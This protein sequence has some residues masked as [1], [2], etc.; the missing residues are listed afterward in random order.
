MK[1]QITHRNEIFRLFSFLLVFAF[2]SAESL[3]DPDPKRFSESFE[4]FARDDQH[5][6]P[7]PAKLALFTGSSSIRRWDSLATDFPEL[8]LLNRGFGGSQISD[9]LYYYPLLFTRYQ[10]QKVIFY[11]G[12]NDLW[13][14][15]PVA[16]VFHDFKT[17]WLKI[18][19]NLP[20]T[21]LFYLSCKPSPKRISKWNLYQS[22]NLKI[23]NLALRD[24]RITFIDLA[25]TLLKPNQSFYP[26]IWDPDN[27]HV[28]ELGYQS[29]RLW[30]RPVL[31]LQN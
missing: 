23:K 29:W 22:L 19:K 16:Q 10:P 17:L 11:C 30:I 24:S 13:K 14:G 21:S 15:K 28:N 5:S 18:K 26:E 6:K 27:L 3:K 1:F 25:P 4:K 31:G 2:S 9:V 8:N 7:N 20:G 12:E